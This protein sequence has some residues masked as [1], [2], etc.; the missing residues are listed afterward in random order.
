MVRVGYNGL[1]RLAHDG[2]HAMESY[3]LEVLVS[4]SGEP[5]SLLGAGT[6][7]MYLLALQECT[8]FPFRIIDEINQGMDEE[9]D[10]RSLE[11][12][13]KVMAARETAGLCC[14]GTPKLPTDIPMQSGTV[15]CVV[16]K[17]SGVLPFLFGEE[18]RCRCSVLDNSGAL[19]VETNR[20]R[21]W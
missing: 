4:F 8:A 20:F 10:R 14:L 21:G 13:T 17:G 19:G 3:R 11:I 15:V 2:E 1:V 6:T 12:G 16:L 9:N 5:V 7:T 18:G